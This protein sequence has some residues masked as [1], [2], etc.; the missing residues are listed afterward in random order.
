MSGYLR[1]PG[2]AK[3]IA[4]T[5]GAVALFRVGQHLPV[6]GTDVAAIG[7]AAD[8]A[9]RADPFAGLVDLLTGGGLLRLSFLGLGVLPYVAATFVVGLLVHTWPRLR[10][11]S[12]AGTDGAKVLLRCTWLLSVAFGAPMGTAAVL[13]AAR[14]DDGVLTGPH[15][16]AVLFVVIGMTAGTMVTA[17]LIRLVSLRG[18][19]EGVGVLFLAQLTAVFP[20]LLWD[21]RDAAGTGTF[22]AATAAVVVSG[23]LVLAAVIGLGQ[24]ERRIPIQFARRMVGVRRRGPAPTYLP[25]RVNS[26]EL[27]PVFLALLLLHVPAVVARLIPGGGVPDGVWTRPDQGDPRFLAALFVL[28]ALLAPTGSGDRIDVHATVARLQR[29]GGFVPG[30]RPGPNT[31]DYL[32]YVR[33]RIRAVAAPALGLCAL[34]PPASL[35]LAGVPGRAPLAGT[36]VLVLV[37]AGLA[38]S[39]RVVRQAEFAYQ[40]HKYL[41][42]LP[43]PPRDP[44]RR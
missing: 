24:A 40:A 6:P 42:Y 7:E 39:R 41:P 4:I 28:A 20:R 25:F 2:L 19:G 1:T 30:I 11:L 33:R 17:W 32:A 35:L 13:A 37:G 21:V 8:A 23:T 29:E 16:R 36:A 9:V 12:A 15:G 14:G 3:R 38:V 31:Y 5:A 26:G 27:F 22:A 34:L 18:L 44:E 10:A 43:T